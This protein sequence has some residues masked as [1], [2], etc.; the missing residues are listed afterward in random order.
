MKILIREAST[1]DA[2]TVIQFQVKMA[3]EIESMCGDHYKMY[4]W[5]KD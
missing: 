1:A 4:E 2:E 3:Y 5:L